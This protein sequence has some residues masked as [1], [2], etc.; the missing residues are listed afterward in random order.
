[1]KKLTAVDARII[2]CTNFHN[3]CGTK[4]AVNLNNLVTMNGVHRH[5]LSSLT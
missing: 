1:M 4:A 3:V 2:N 5:T